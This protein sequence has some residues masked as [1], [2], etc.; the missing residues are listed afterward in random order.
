MKYVNNGQQLLHVQETLDGPVYTHI[1]DARDSEAAHFLAAAGNTFNT[2]N[3]Y[4][5]NALVTLSPSWH[6]D[7]VAKAQFLGRINGA[8][9]A[10]N[11]LDAVK[12]TLFYG[13]D[14]NLIAEGQTPLGEQL[15]CDMGD[16]NAD[17]RNIVHGVIGIFTEAG[18]LLEA[19][20][21]GYNS[22]AGIDPINMREEI[23]D[24]FWYVAILLYEASRDG[25]GM[26]F[27]DAMRVNIAKLRARYPD[28]FNE[29]DANE[30]NLANERVILEDSDVRTP[31][32]LTAGVVG[33]GEYPPE[34]NEGNP[35]RREELGLAPLIAEAPEVGGAEAVAAVAESADR[36][37]AAIK[38][39]G[40]PEREDETVGDLGELSKPIG[41][42]QA[43][44]PQEGAAQ[45]SGRAIERQ[46]PP[47]GWTPSYPGD[48]SWRGKGYNP[49]LGYDG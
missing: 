13:R 23:G 39:V 1:A 19:L 37:F 25:D 40:K 14:N 5:D 17:P 48:Q 35:A 38:S 43:P 27:E 30:R 32:G 12:K 11:K 44:M 46:S 41:E 3:N 22:Q 28:K 15:L 49:G 33:S 4:V 31:I 36:A 34:L 29:R 16:W 21:D 42:R 9:D 10:A 18:E 26:T 8:I 7:K 47:E 2:V 24:M 45:A 6:G 20:R